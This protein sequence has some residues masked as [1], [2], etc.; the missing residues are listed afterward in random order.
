M[1]RL[2][3]KRNE[4]YN[5]LV[6]DTLKKLI[7]L[8]GDSL[9]S[10]SSFLQTTGKAKP[11]LLIQLDEPIGV[12][13]KSDAVSQNR[14]KIKAMLKEVSD[15]VILI[16]TAGEIAD[17]ADDFPMEHIHIKNRYRK[18]YGDDPIGHMEVCFE[19]VQRAVKSSMQNTLMRLRT[20][21]L[22]QNY[23]DLFVKELIAQLYPTFESALYL[24]SQSIPTGLQEI[25]FKIESCYNTKNN[26]L[27]EI[28]QNI[29][30]GTTAGLSQ[31]M[32]GLLTA[33]EE[34][35]A[36]VKGLKGLSAEEV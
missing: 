11:T 13:M 1:V 23:N 29:E 28:A 32:F 17:F 24:R 36:G 21:Y 10:V 6:D 19:N 25:V 2:T 20:A 8:F 12:L 14:K 18:L 22:S 15:F 3:E 26:V 35:L 27:S 7:D 30:N 33:L 16:T 9:L 5:K 31:N 4:H 34:I